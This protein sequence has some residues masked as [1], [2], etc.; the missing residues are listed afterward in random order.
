MKR[1]DF[2]RL[3]YRWNRKIHEGRGRA[4]SEGNWGRTA[5]RPLALA[6][7]LSFGYDGLAIESADLAPGTRNPLKRRTFVTLFAGGLLA[8]PFI[9]EAHPARMVKVGWLLPPVRLIS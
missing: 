6:Q 3:S 7:P 8:A 9:S 1:L 4:G 5:H 2:W